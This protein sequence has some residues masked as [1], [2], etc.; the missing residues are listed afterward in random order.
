MTLLV[1]D[2]MILENYPQI[3]RSYVQIWI[4]ESNIVADLVTFIEGLS[5]HTPNL[6]EEPDLVETSLKSTYEVIKVSSS[7]FKQRYNFT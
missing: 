1:C 4:K 6:D 7:I 3:H 5:L 2:Y